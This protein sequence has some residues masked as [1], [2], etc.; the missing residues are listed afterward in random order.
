MRFIPRTVIAAGALALL[1][2]GFEAVAQSDIPAARR[3]PA[4]QKDLYAID[5]VPPEFAGLGQQAEVREVIGT[6][7]AQ[8]ATELGGRCRSVRMSQIISAP[9]LFAEGNDAH[10]SV[11]Y[12]FGTPD[13]EQAGVDCKGMNTRLF[14]LT[15]TA[16]G[17]WAVTS[18]SPVG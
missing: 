17:G 11:A 2:A 13:P 14:T 8:H 15:R 7:Y 10:L 18:M 6:Y 16:G 5:Q 12:Y 3:A 4:G 9:T 1:G